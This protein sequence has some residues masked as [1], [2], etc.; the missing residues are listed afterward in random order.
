[1]N[2]GAA[3]PAVGAEFAKRFA[4]VAGSVGGQAHGFADGGQTSATAAGSQ[5]VLEGQLRVDVDEA[6]GH[7]QVL[8]D[9][10]CALAF[11]GLDLVLRDPV[12]F[13]AR[14]VVVDLRGT[15]AVR[16][17]G[18]AQITRVRNTRGTVFRRSRRIG[19]G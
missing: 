17:V 7:H 6:A 11:K 4:I 18:A 19:G 2:V 10:I 3:D 5:G 13:L 15:L 1:M 9:P 12:E 14:N 8:G 16:A